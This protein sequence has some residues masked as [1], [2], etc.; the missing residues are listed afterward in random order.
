MFGRSDLAPRL[1]FGFKKFISCEKV[2]LLLR[3]GPIVITFQPEFEI[4][5]PLSFL[6]HNV[7]VQTKVSPPDF[8]LNFADKQL[9]VRSNGNAKQ[10]V[11]PILTGT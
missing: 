8:F 3:N 9:K 2:H 6:A 11:Y 7:F 5:V 10:L 1:L 4:V